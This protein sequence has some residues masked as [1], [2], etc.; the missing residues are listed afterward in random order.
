VY[1]YVWGKE[2]PNN[3]CNYFWK[4]ILAYPLVLL[5]TIFQLFYYPLS[6]I[7]SLK[8][9]T[10]GDNFSERLVGALSISVYFLL[11]CIGVFVSSAWVIY[12]EGSFMFGL[13]A[14]GGGLLLFV[15]IAVLYILILKL[16]QKRKGLVGEYIKAKKENYC[17][18]IEWIDE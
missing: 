17:P 11:F 18:K 10:E 4:S 1:Q 2:L 3:L 5:V 15:S 9:E 12:Y 7:P 14:T 6:L 8:E 16:F 13:Y